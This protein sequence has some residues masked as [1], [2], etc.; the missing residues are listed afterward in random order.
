MVTAVLAEKMTTAKSVKSIRKVRLRGRVGS[1]FLGQS[2]ESF[3]PVPLLGA[4]SS[5][6]N[7]LQLQ[8][9]HCQQFATGNAALGKRNPLHFIPIR[10]CLHHAVDSRAASII[11]GYGMIHHLQGAN[12]ARLAKAA[13]S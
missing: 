9:Q 8:G 3:N 7:Q 10:R 13:S 6:E 4:G 2:M 12:P 5:C 11:H 1:D